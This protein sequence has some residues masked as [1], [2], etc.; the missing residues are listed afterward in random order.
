[1]EE[2][3]TQL[4]FYKTILEK[5]SFDKMLFEKEF[6]KAIVDLSYKDSIELRRWKR[7]FIFEKIQNNYLRKS[8]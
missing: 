1:M 8:S 6:N 2:K 7:T 4:E 5:V 3:N